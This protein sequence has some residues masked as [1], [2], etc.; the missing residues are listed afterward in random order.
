MLHPLYSYIQYMRSPEFILPI[1][2]FPPKATMRMVQEED[3][4]RGYVFEDEDHLELCG[5]WSAI[6]FDC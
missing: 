4:W 6:V 5:L 1:P 3:W 2:S